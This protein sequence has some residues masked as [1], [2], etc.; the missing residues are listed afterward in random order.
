MIVSVALCTYNGAK[1]IETQLRSILGQT[2]T[3][4][5]IVVCDDG[6]NDGTVEIVENMRKGS[7]V[8]IL[9][10]R[11]ERNVG[12]K[13]NFFNAIDRCRGDLVFL[14]DQDDAWHPNK[15][16][17]V[18]KWF[19]LH[20]DKQA[21]FT[22]ALLM[23]ENG[24]S[25]EGNLWQRFGFD[26]KKQ[27]FFDHGCA[28]DIWMWSNR[29]TGATM[30]VKKDFVA[31]ASWRGIADRYHDH[32][33]AWQGVVSHS[34]G[35]IDEK[36]MDYRLHEEQVCGA[37]GMPS[38]LQY[39]PLKPCPEFRFGCD[40]DSLPVREQK[41]VDFILKRASFKNTWFGWGAIANLGS[42]VKIYHGWA[43]K[44]FL[45]DYGVSVKH[46]LKRVLH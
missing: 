25:V 45:Y 41:Q 6:S 19:E 28:L 37:K 31:T 27:R 17:T 4:D 24:V 7:D 34:L 12:F 18:V 13:E 42:Y 14:A 1:Y 44:F 8:S 22:D 38:E 11:N 26:K 23:D 32:I 10:F 5:E 21:V 36:L 3:V 20:P 30:A 33:I 46:S 15:V 43:Y 35:Y 2:R 16:E 39:L 29:A 40:R 9:L